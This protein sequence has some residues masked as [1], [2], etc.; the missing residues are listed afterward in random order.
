MGRRKMEWTARGVARS[1]RGK[2][3]F[4][5]EVGR[6]ANP[7]PPTDRQRAMLQ[8][9]GLWTEGMTKSQAWWIVKWC[10]GRVKVLP[11]QTEAEIAALRAR[12][13]G[14]PGPA[15]P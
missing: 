8:R 14:R 10:L 12:R 7:G 5:L 15:V 3:L 1:R 13:E 2:F 4:V 6:G 9:N 11:D